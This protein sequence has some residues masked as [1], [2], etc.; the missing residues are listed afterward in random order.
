MY[1]AQH[2]IGRKMLFS[3]PGLRNPRPTLGDQMINNTF[4]SS[5]KYIFHEKRIQF[6]QNILYFIRNISIM[7]TKDESFF[8]E[9]MYF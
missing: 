7:S 4:F 2:D 6:H 1:T 3:K 8:I 9:N 5:K